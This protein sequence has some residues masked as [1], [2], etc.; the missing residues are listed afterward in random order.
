MPR[1]KEAGVPEPFALADL[2]IPEGAE[3]RRLLERCPDIE[4][5]RF[6]DGEYL[7]REGGEGR[8]VFLVLKGSC[9]VEQPGARAAGPRLPETLAVITSTPGAPSFVGEMA[10]F[11]GE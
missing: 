9:S 3:Y 8:E 1:R 4:K 2:E 10:Y 5:Q 11:G 7:L 6:V